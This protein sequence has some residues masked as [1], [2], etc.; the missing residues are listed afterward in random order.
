[1]IEEPGQTDE[2]TRI[3]DYFAGAKWTTWASGRDHLLAERRELLA[4][5]SRMVTE[6]S[7][8]D[9]RVLDVGCG[10]GADLEFWRSMGVPES[11]LAGTELVPARAAA[12]AALLP[13]A[14]IVL[15]YDFALPFEDDA[16]DVTTAA[17]VL[18]TITQTGLRR[19]LFQE[20]LRVTRAGGVVAVYDFRIRKPSNRAVTPI[21]PTRAR[22]LGG[23][24]ASVR[25]AAP[26]LPALPLVLRLP[27]VARDLA[28]KLLPR[29]HAMYVWRP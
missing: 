17:L 6:R 4:D 2:A 26:F 11:Q 8:N 5:L 21:T 9:L 27:R 18:S 23:D 29:T 22:A 3:R 1:M 14:N 15:T 24:P 16:F 25:L 12:A 19:G 20:M 10:G 28:I 7:R 13:K